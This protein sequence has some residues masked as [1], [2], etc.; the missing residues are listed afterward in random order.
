MSNFEVQ[1]TISDNGSEK[2]YSNY[3]IC[4]NLL[5]RI[6]PV[7]ITDIATV[8]AQTEAGHKYTIEGIVTSNASGYDKATAFFDCIYVQDETG[9]INCFPVAG[10]FKIGDVVRVTGVTETY[11]GEN[12][13][14][15]SSIEKIGETTPVTPRAVTSTQ[16]ND[17][18]VLGQLVTL[19]GYVTGYEMADGGPDHS[20]PRQRGQDRP[21]VHRRLYHHLLRCG[22]PVRGLPDL[23]HGPG[24]L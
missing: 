9:G 21:R 8:Q 15:V 2:N 4:E 16:I 7:K 14:Q 23:R 3:K 13:L 19:N 5:G 1:A 17:G 10:D 11:Q 12:E 18:S 6:N 22:E 24:L 20:G